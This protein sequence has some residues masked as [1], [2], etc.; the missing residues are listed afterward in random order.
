M[1]KIFLQ[2]P[3]VDEDE[4]KLVEEVLISKNLVEG[5]MVKELEYLVAKYVKVFH[6][7]ACTSATIGLELALRAVGVGVASARPLTYSCYD[8]VII[9]DFTHPATGLVVK[10]LLACPVLIDV[11][12]NTGNATADKIEAAITPNTRA[13]M[14][15]S[16]FGNPLEMKDILRV[17]KKYKLPVIE[18]AACSLGS[19]LYDIP[20]GSMADISVF[21][22]H[23]RKVFTS[24][25]GGIVV[26]NNVKFAAKIR[27]MKNFGIVDNDHIGWGSNY[28]M[29]DIL[30]AVALGQLQR[31][32][33][34]INMR[35]FLAKQYDKLLKNVDGIKLLNISLYAESNYQTYCVYIE[36][37]RRDE[38]IVEMRK[39]G[40][41]VQIGTYALHELPI[42]KNTKRVGNLPNS[43]KLHK[44]LLALP[45]H[46]ELTNEDQYRVVSTLKELL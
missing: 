10:T 7:I 29:S 17:A 34:I 2:R 14:P 9:P 18:D 21:S 39:L 42:F 16:I 23:P 19:K 26:T 35:Y 27:A 37:E 43:S 24:G 30:G 31:L 25:E 3:N 38:I 1:A 15:V 40:I 22:L 12:L 6:A 36:S 33:E 32:D 11:E 41:E 46:Q 13:I 28:R 4:L 5:K 20:V 8:E 44:H 45:L